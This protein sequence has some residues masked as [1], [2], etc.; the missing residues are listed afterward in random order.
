MSAQ[1]N[2]A[3][4]RLQAGASQQA[5][6]RHFSISR[7]I[8]SALWA[9]YNKVIMTDHG[10]YIRVQQ[11][12][13]WSATMTQIPWPWRISDQRVHNRLMETGIFPRKLVSCNPM[14]LSG[15]SAVEPAESDMD[16]W[17]VEDC[18]L[19]WVSFSP[20]MCWWMLM[21]TCIYRCPGEHYAP[22]CVGGGSVMVWAVS[23]CGQCHGVGRNP[24]WW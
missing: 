14:S 16:M 24:L 2:N 6:A 7:Q 1:H 18:F 13:N 5:V 15:A 23:W 3:T 17:Q 4:G 21:D 12:Q 19:G 20:A 9:Q 22:H 8:I 11:L 10:Q